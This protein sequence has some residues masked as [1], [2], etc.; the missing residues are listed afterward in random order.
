MGPTRAAAAALFFLLAACAPPEPP[1]GCVIGVLTPEGGRC[2]AMRDADDHLYSF[3]ADMI[4]Y[5]IGDTVCVCGGEALMSRCATGTPLE[6][7]H[8]GPSCPVE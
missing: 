2:Q 6:V 8:L 3:Y 4:D 5:K 7:D 1:P